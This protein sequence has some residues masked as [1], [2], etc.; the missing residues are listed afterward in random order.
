[1]LLL[2]PMNAPATDEDFT[3]ALANFARGAKPVESNVT[4]TIEPLVDNGNSVPVGISADLPLT[5]PN[6][7]THLA[8][9]SEKNP[10]PDIAVF[11]CSPLMG[12]ADVSTRIR[13]AGTQRVAAMARTA[14]GC[15]YMKSLEVIVT[16]AACAEMD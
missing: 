2:R 6:A 4:L 12:R 8:L 13:L 15:V 7:V 9:L 5:G 10:Q 1:M 3:R 16:T 14:D 11:E